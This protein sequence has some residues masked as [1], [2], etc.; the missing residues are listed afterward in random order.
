[1]HRY[2]I[3]SGSD[4]DIYFAHRS[5]SIGLYGVMDQSE[6]ILLACENELQRH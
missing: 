5:N 1:M 2:L 3:Y 6:I 4:F